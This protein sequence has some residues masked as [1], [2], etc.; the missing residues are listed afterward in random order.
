MPA[1]RSSIASVSVRAPTSS[2]SRST[3]GTRAPATA[4][5]VSP[6]W[7]SASRSRLT[8][9]PGGPRRAL[10]PTPPSGGRRWRRAVVEPL[11]GAGRLA[12]AV[13]LVPGVG[14]GG[15]LRGEPGVAEVDPVGAGQP[16]GA[17]GDRRGQVADLVGRPGRSCSRTRPA[18]TDQHARG[19]PRAAKRRMTTIR[20][21]MPSWRAS[22]WSNTL[23]WALRT[24]TALVATNPFMASQA[25]CSAR[26][27]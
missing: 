5:G 22:S 6:S 24:L 2:M 9:G 12:A 4:R 20:R 19:R 10:P 1:S 7:V 21:A 18:A 8:A 16:V 27:R 25:R 11:A 3:T 17:V 14:G 15:R 13:P 23:G 26:S